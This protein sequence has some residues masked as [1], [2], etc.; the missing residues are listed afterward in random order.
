MAVISTRPAHINAAFA[1][2]SSVPIS[3]SS[4]M[5]LPTQANRITRDQTEARISLI[6]PTLA[7]A[8]DNKTGNVGHRQELKSSAAQRLWS[9]IFTANGVYHSP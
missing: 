2:E 7:A 4:K 3:F 1:P 9:N 5:G 8:E 6:H